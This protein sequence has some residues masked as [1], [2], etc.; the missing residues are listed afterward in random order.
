MCTGRM[1]KRGYSLFF[2]SFKVINRIKAIALVT[3]T[4]GVYNYYF[5]LADPICEN[6]QKRVLPR[7]CIKSSLRTVHM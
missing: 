1:D 6:Q 2:V 4:E 7:Y 5:R 3:E